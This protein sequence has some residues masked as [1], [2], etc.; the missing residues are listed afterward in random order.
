MLRRIVLIIV[1][2]I[3]AFLL[4]SGGSVRSGLEWIAK[5]VV[6]LFLAAAATDIADYTFFKKQ[7]RR[8]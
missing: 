2:M 3:A 6:V 5:I 8:C 7:S 1:F 4:Y